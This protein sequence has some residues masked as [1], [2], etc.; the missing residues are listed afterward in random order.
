WML[1]QYMYA[2]D[3]QM[4]AKRGLA[5]RWREQSELDNAKK[6]AERLRE[7][8]DDAGAKKVERRAERQVKASQ[9]EFV[10]GERSM[11]LVMGLLLVGFQSF[12]LFFFGWFLLARRKRLAAPTSP[13][14]A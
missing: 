2:S 5:S 3:E 13:E 12:V 1:A 11:A 14:D 7:A 6:K 10:R 9:R 4:L 8:G